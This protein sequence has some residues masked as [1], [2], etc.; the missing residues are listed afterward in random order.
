MAELNPGRWTA[1]IEGDFV[2]F[3]IGARINSKL[4][5]RKHNSMIKGE[6]IRERLA[7]AAPS[8]R[9]QRDTDHFNRA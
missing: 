7:I 3:I 1:E 9:Q 5:A 8:W 4:Q 2:V 6:L